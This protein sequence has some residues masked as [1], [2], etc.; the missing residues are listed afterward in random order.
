MQKLTAKLIG[1]IGEEAAKIKLIDEGYELVEY[2]REM[3]KIR[4]PNA[5]EISRIHN[6]WVGSATANLSEM[7]KRSDNNWIIGNLPPWAD[8]SSSEISTLAQKCKQQSICGMRDANPDQAPCSNS[9]NLFSKANLSGLYPEGISNIKHQDESGEMNACSVAFHCSRRFNTLLSLDSAGKVIPRGG[10][11]RD[12]ALIQGY[13][14]RVSTRH[15]KQN[16]LPY[17]GDDIRKAGLNTPEAEKLKD[18][19]REV[20]RARNSNKSF[21]DGHPGRY[22]FIGY[23]DGKH[24]AIEVKV[25][26]SNLSYWQM[27]RFKLLNKL[28]HE[29][30]L[31]RVFA[32]K[33]ELEN[34]AD[35]GSIDGFRFEFEENPV[36]SVDELYNFEEALKYQVHNPDFP[37]KNLK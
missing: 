22:D 2:G 19:N 36:F 34:Y 27:L 1:A 6:Y 17:S 15:N 26:S 24:V 29:T 18:A 5:T 12:N 25:N 3:Q 16:P 30:M 31:V 10:F 4:L 14:D 33:A 9:D 21:P 8:L 13:M 28:G 35:N 32:G 23:K 20:I 37:R 7:Q 11:M